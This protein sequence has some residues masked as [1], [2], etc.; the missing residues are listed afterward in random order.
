MSETWK[1]AIPAERTVETIAMVRSMI[2]GHCFTC[3]GSPQ[4]DSS[5]A[6]TSLVALNTLSAHLDG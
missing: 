3:P 4:I 1:R 2:E 6:R 5:F